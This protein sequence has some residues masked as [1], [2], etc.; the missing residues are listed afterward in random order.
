MLEVKGLHKRY[1]GLVAVQEVSFTARPGEAVGLLGP[2][3]A[4]KTTTVAM[5]AGLLAPDSGEV[6]IEGGVVRGETDP[7]KRKM[8]L[9][10]QDLALHDPLSAR[11]NLALFGAL[12]G[13]RGAELRRAM[14]AALDLVGLADRARDRV[15]TFSGGMKRRLNM[16]GALLHDPAILLLDEP[17]VGVDPQSRNAIFDNLEELKR[18]GKTLVYTTHYM[19]EAERLCDRII[20]VDHGKVI[21]NDSLEAVRRLVPGVNVIEIEIE[22]PG[23]D[24]GAGGLAAGL[25]DPG[26]GQWYCG[27]GA[28]EGVDSVECLGSLLRV[29]MRDLTE[30][31]P[32]VL[33]WLRAHGYRC[34]HLSSQRADLETVF[35]T[36]TGR[37]VRNA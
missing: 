37:S 30:T 36:L 12:Y 33:E 11:D 7:I 29:T 16:A 22:N 9:V 6:R 4:G 26:Q 23:Q 21:A 25:C 5:I 24:G 35:L 17:T 8:G 10:P 2:N 18:Q 27:L 28:L 3:G 13:M 1:G 20:I 34:L 32:A 14:D 15:S 31:S 19:E